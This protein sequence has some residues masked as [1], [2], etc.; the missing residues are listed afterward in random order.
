MA[1]NLTQTD[2]VGTCALDRYCAVDASTPEARRECTDGGTAGTS[3]VTL[4]LVKNSMADNRIQ[5]ECIIVAGTSW[6][7]GTWTV[8]LNVTTA[9]ANIDWDTVVICR[10]NSSC[11]N[12]ETI[13]TTNNLAISCGTTGVKSTSVTG[14]AQ[15]PGVGDK[16]MVILGFDNGD[17]M[18]AQAIGITPS[19]DI[20]SP[21]TVAGADI[22]A[23]IMAP[24]RAA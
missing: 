19:E 23:L 5:F 22:P 16:V 4:T 13:G 15:S 7:G 24:Y 11:A 6:D 8:R 14:A 3:E 2:T 12:Q 18:N 1:I 21:F 10:L 17:N 9:N 20:D